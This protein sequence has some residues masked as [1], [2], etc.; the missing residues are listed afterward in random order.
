MT[1]SAFSQPARPALHFAFTGCVAAAN[2]NLSRWIKQMKKKI[3][4]ITV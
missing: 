3:M 2:E 4:E 1:S